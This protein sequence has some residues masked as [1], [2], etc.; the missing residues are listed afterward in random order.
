MIQWQTCDF[1]CRRP[2]NVLKILDSTN[3]KE[4]V[5]QRLR[6]DQHQYNY[7]SIYVSLDRVQFL[8][9]I[10]NYHYFNFI[11]IP[12]WGS[13]SVC[14]THIDREENVDLCNVK[15][16]EIDGKQQGERKIRKSGK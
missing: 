12:F 5:R 11:N 10:D 13:C 3:H 4:N 1:E 14:V 6:M 9:H 16:C 2:N 8:S 15:R 7:V